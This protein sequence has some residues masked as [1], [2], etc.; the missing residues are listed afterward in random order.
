VSVELSQNTRE[1]RFATVTNAVE[2][3]TGRK[4]Q[5]LREWLY[6][7]AAATARTLPA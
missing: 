2:Q 3:L 6:P 1:G 7:E 5:A 4:P